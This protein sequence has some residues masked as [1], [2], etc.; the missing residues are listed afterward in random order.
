MKLVRSYLEWARGE[1]QFSPWALLV[2]LA[3]V[4]QSFARSRNFAFDHGLVASYEPPIPVISVGNITLG[5]TNKTP[6]V[7]M[8]S[9]HFYNMGVRVGIVSRGYGGRT[10]EPVVIKGTSS[11]REIVG[12]EPLLLASRLPHV[13][14]AVSRDRLK[15]VEA[16][17]K[18][19]VELIVADDA[20]QHRRLGRDVDI[21]LVDA[22]CPFGNGRLVPA[23]ILR[24]P[25][26]AIQRAHIVV[27]TKADQVSEDE[28]RSLRQKLLQYI[29][30]DRLFT[31]RL[32]LRC[33]SLWDGSWQDMEDFTVKSLPVVAFSAIGSPESFR[34]T[35]DQAGLRVLREQ[36]FKDHHRFDLR[37]MERLAALK[38]ELGARYLVCT[39]KDV[40]NLPKE[41]LISPLLVPIISTVID[42]ED[43]FWSIVAEKLRPRLVVASNGYGEDA[44]GALLAQKVKKRF[45]C[46]Y[47]TSFP[48]VGKGEQY[49]NAGISV[50]SVP[51]ESPSG[52]VIKYHISDL[53]KDLKSGLVRHIFSQLK[54]WK[55]L[56]GEV[57]TPLCVGDVYLLLHTL[58]GQGQLPV[59]VATAKTVY[60]SG[61]WRLERFLLKHRCRRVWTR[62]SETAKE[63]VRSH[64]DA[65]FAGNPIMDLTC[66]NNSGYFQWP[67]EKGARVLLLPGSRQRAYDDMKMLLD[68]VEFLNKKT[69]CV[70]VAVIAPSLDIE[71]LVAAAPGWRL[72]DDGRGIV[73]NGLRVLFYLGPLV[74]VAT[75]AH[76]LI[77]LGGTANQVCAGLGVPV[78]SIREKGKLVQKKLLGDSEI[79]VSPDPQVLADTAFVILSDS[80]LRQSMGEEG[81]K[82]LGGPGA[83]DN[84]VEYVAR[85]Y[86]WDLRCRV[87]Q[88]I[89][90]II[91][92]GDDI[93]GSYSTN[94]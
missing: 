49:E 44:M 25:P 20:F 59:L 94:S 46:A 68:A 65:V 27:I 17:Q 66:D 86:G 75:D 6:F 43:R 7:E 78:V 81:K 70:F 35:L 19:N 57:R 73:K 16:L 45:P 47:V 89:S 62:D 9:R 2:P 21:V 23:G 41:P 33:W 79:L 1:R 76:I 36:R 64:A 10:S 50:D 37:D 14:V 87:Y 11:E 74:S 4:S 58:W 85:E 60:L 69:S 5:G 91:N 30:A 52:G 90:R 67:K 29:P 84:V 26:K 38:E 24:E 77:G 40:Y 53:L 18:H 83:L 63:L 61:H 8:L 82:R 39:E 32:E 92:Q 28:L 42:E 56:R 34:R 3:C 72:A 93:H 48:I 12:D 13:P 80:E 51:S 71:Q 22:C 88:K 15:D 55:K 31:S 54:A